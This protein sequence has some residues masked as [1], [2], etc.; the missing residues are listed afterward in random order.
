[1]LSRM[2]KNT[3]SGLRRRIVNKWE[4]IREHHLTIMT[5]IF[6]ITLGMMIYTLTFIIRGASNFSDEI[7]VFSWVSGLIGVIVAI[8][9]WPEFFYLRGRYNFLR[10][11]MQIESPSELR[12]EMGDAQDAAKVL[13]NRYQDKL[14]EHLRG[15]GI[16]MKRKSK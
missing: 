8:F 5:T 6:V 16:Q 11:Y 13:G 15:K 2:S 10:E 14:Q 12:R 3:E 9:L 1:M 4:S 7:I